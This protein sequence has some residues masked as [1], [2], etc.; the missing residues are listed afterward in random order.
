MHKV[1]VNKNQL[2][3]FRN[4]A[5]N[6]PKEIQAYLI[7]KIVSPTLTVIEKFVY[8]NDYAIQTEGEVA[9]YWKDYVKAKHEAEEKGLRVIGDIH[10]HPNWDAVMS[11]DDYHNFVGEGF[12]ICGIVSTRERKTRVR[13]WIAESALP[14]DIDYI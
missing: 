8:T 10:S 14:C 12:R 13:F 2:N 9:W 11:P 3:Y 7:G 4:L 1:R 6:T 5:R